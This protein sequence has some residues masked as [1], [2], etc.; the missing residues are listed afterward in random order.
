LI[1][2]ATPVAG[3]ILL[4]YRQVLIGV[5]VFAILIGG[6]LAGICGSGHCTRA[7]ASVSPSFAPT[8]APTQ[9]PPVDQAVAAPIIDYINNITFNTEPLTYPPDRDT[10]SAEELS[11]EWLIRDLAREGLIGNN[12]EP[13]DPAREEDVSRMTQR[14][15]LATLWFSTDGAS[16]RVNDGWLETI[17]ECSWFGVECSGEEVVGAF[18]LTPVVVLDLP[19]NKL[20]GT[21]PADIALL[22]SLKWFG[23]DDNPSLSGSLPPS[24]MELQGLEILTLGYCNLTG[25][26]SNGK[27]EFASAL[28]VFPHY[29]YES[30]TFLHN[31]L[32]RLWQFDFFETSMALRQSF[33]WK[34][35]RDCWTADSIG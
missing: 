5:G 11:M 28:L 31:V 10:A 30:P 8:L 29:V 20:N 27:C 24:F 16:W 7:A 14:Y 19:D 18:N 12:T 32:L 17:D 9:E 35:S 2:E 25:S 22:Q 33:H 21:I 13:L 3:S 4:D 6:V 23:A 1:T 34:A 15:A 26:I